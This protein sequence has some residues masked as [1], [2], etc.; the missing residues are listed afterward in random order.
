MKHEMDEQEYAMS[1]PR[2]EPAPS[3]GTITSNHKE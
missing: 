3:V 1:M 2:F